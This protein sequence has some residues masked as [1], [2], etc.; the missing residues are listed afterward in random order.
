MYR[1]LLIPLDGS[2]LAECVLPHVE[3]LINGCGVE[4]IIFVRVVEPVT[5]PTGTLT[6]GAAVFTEADAMKTRK[7]IDA[8]NEAEAKQY[9]QGMLDRFKSGGL[10]VDMALLRGKSAD[11]LIDYIQKS[12]AD[13]VIIASHGRSG[14]SRWIYGSVAE[15]LLRSVCIPLLMVRA[16]G[17]V[18]GI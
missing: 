6:D 5:L 11:E 15:R 9:L 14:I 8:R 3:T 1:K 18:P 16:P 10:K 7:S 12:D 13:L 2:E 4:E 17:C